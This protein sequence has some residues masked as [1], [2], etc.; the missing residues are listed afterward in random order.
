MSKWYDKLGSLALVRQPVEEK[1]N[2]EFKPTVFHL[3]IDTTS[4]PVCGRGVG[5]VYIRGGGL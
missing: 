2:S 5:F 3:K 4:Y 1:E